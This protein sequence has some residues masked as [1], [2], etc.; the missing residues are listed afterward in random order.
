ME[1]QEESDDEELA[2]RNDP[3]VEATTAGARF[4]VPESAAISQKRKINVNG[5]KYQQRRL[6]CL[7]A[8]VVKSKTCPWDRLKDFPKQHFAVVEG[9]L[10][11][12]ACGE[13][14]S[15]KKSSIE[16]HVKHLNGVESIA[17]SKKEN[18]SIVQCLKKQD[19]RNI[20]GSTLPEEMR[21]FRF[22]LTESF[23][24]A[25]IPL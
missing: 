16:K 22:E 17:K 14:L 18:Q 10:R 3:I 4:Q 12:N 23:L 13:I 20:S 19:K 2:P 24:S 8:T 25:G 11:C 1:E 7:D 15:L 9:I 5:R 6:A 21:V